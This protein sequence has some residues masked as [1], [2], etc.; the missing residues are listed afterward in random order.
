MTFSIK[1]HGVTIPMEGITQAEWNRFQQH[2]AVPADSDGKKMFPLGMMSMIQRLAPIFCMT[3]EEWEATPGSPNFVPP[4][5]TKRRLIDRYQKTQYG[6]QKLIMKAYK[7]WL[8][9]SP[10]AK[11]DKKVRMDLLRALRE[12]NKF[13]PCIQVT[14]RL[15]QEEG[16]PGYEQLYRDRRIVD[17]LVTE[18]GYGVHEGTAIWADWEDYFYDLINA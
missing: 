11:K 4:E 14:Q 10:M 7:A 17:F 2:L 6:D 16:L 18:L 9:E 3:M 8:Q 15:E 1:A 5:E 13:S 12:Y